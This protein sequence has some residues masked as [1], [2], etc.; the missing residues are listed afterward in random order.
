ML[1]KLPRAIGRALK[2][3]R[4]GLE[5]T[6]YFDEALHAVPETLVL[7]SP[8][9]D[10]EGAIPADFTADGPG[11]SPP[12]HWSNLPEEAAALVFVIEDADSPTPQPLT[13]AIVYDLPPTLTGFAAGALRSANHSGEAYAMGK[14]SRH[15]LE[16]LPPD[17]PPGHGVHRYVFQL[18][19]LDAATGVP[20]HPSKGDIKEALLDRVISRGL[21][22]GI[23]E[24]P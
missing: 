12:V 5:K 19:A 6:L 20:D 13:H 23:Y 21:L 11:L 2:H 14:N 18:Y 22:I 4:P 9:F 8:T 10:F 7:T 3:A 16:Y 1:E 17:P 24:R 15:T